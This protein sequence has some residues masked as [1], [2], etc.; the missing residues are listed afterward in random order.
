[1]CSLSLLKSCLT[2]SQL[3]KHFAKEF[4][5]KTKVALDVP[6]TEAASAADK[7]AEAKLRLAVE[8]TKRSLSASSGAATCAV[9]SLKD[10]YDLSGAINR[11]RFDGLAAGVYRQ[12][13]AKVAA[14]VEKAGL[15]LAQIDEI[16]LA[17]ASTLFPGLQ[18]HLAL[19]VAPTTPVTAVL[20]PAE[21]IAIGCAL[22][23]LHLATLPE[24]LKLQDILALPTRGV[25]TLAQPIAL[26]LP[27]S[28]DEI[29]AAKLVE[30]GAALPVRRRVAIPLAKGT[31]G[32]VAFELW[33]AKDEVK[34]E[35]VERAPVEKSEEDEE[36]SDDE[37]E[38]DEEIKTAITKKTNLLTAVEVESH[39][40]DKIYVEL[41][42]AKGAKL[43]VRAW[44]EG[45]EAEAL[46][47]SV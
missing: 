26:V 19:L 29:V 16:L 15:E 28:T 4:T 35:K 25:E 32:K 3:L 22:Q 43:E 45:K 24:E 27:G 13:G 1:M 7:R 11:M 34:V 42:V 9:E 40:A 47:V 37:D 18:A 12:V 10:G 23:A 30:S 20:D 31:S 6:C 8:H 17:G 38:E 33:E 41:I 36:F 14:V 2:L 39:G 21:V 5:K 44:A 46:V